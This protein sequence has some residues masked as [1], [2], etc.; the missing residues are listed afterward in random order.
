MLPIKYSVVVVLAVLSVLGACGGSGSDS[1]PDPDAN[2]IK[3]VKDGDRYAASVLAD[4]TPSDSELLRVGHKFCDRLKI[5]ANKKIPILGNPPSLAM[6]MKDDP[7]WQTIS[8]VWQDAAEYL[9]PDQG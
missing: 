3:S 9:C 5:E 2:F 7:D 1:R 8:L 4:Q 6:S